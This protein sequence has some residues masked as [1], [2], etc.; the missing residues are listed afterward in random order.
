MGLIFGAFLGNSSPKKTEAVVTR[1]LTE[2]FT[3]NLNAP[4][5]K[6]TLDRRAGL[7]YLEILKSGFKFKV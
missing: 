3:L 6:K 1:N 5:A 7:Q 2:K 4:N